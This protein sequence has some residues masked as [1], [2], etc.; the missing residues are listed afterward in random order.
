MKSHSQ[1]QDD[2]YSFLEQFVR[3]IESVRGKD[4][5]VAE[6]LYDVMKAAAGMAE[7]YDFI[8]DFIAAE[9][10][11]IAQIDRLAAFRNSFE[12]KA[13][14]VASNVRGTQLEWF[15]A[16]KNLSE[17]KT[18]A[19]DLDKVLDPDMRIE[20][21]SSTGKAKV[22]EFKSTAGTAGTIDENTKSQLNS[23]IFQLCKRTVD[24]DG[25]EFSSKKL[26]AVVEVNYTDNML[27]DTIAEMGALSPDEIYNHFSEIITS[28]WK[29][30]KI[31]L[32]EISPMVEVNKLGWNRTNPPAINL[33]ND[34]PS[35]FTDTA[36]QSMFQI[37]FIFQPFIKS[38]IVIDDIASTTFCRKAKFLV[39][40]YEGD[41][42][43][44]I[45]LYK[46]MMLKSSL[47][48]DGQPMY[49]LFDRGT[50]IVMRSF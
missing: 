12:K 15:Q 31:G 24:H 2:V 27:F 5:E 49:T 40:F 25:I 4:P 33:N 18:I 35:Q 14:G 10:G 50:D 48:M 39:Y 19:I 22:I 46:K 42:K 36:C 44:N 47:M 34:Y 43:K 28:S 45:A 38:K 1:F 16:A 41:G 21:E 8:A 3:T 9:S 23:A 26:K 20:Y 7:S 32:G 29:K 6:Q 11:Q 13:R 30:N 17:G 37:V